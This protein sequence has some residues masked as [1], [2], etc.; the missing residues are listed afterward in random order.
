MRS[1]PCSSA[2]D[3]CHWLVAKIFP[4]KLT[5]CLGIFLN[6]GSRRTIQPVLAIKRKPP[7]LPISVIQS[8]QF[9]VYQTKYVL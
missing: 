9:S 3:R 6:K 4:L 7:F 2:L 5:H 8:S 1:P